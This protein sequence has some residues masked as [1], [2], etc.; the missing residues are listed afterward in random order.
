MKNIIFTK[1]WQGYKK[2]DKLEVNDTNYNKLVNVFEVSKDDSI[3]KVQKETNV[4]S[5]KSKKSK[6]FFG[7]KKKLK[8]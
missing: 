6:D 2:G 5:N 8:K 4:K 7:V 1:D 3:E